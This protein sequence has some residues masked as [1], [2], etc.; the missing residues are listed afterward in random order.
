[1]ILRDFA[2]RDV[3]RLPE[4]LRP[5]RSMGFSCR[6]LQPLVLLLGGN[7]GVGKTTLAR[8]LSKHHLR[9]LNFDFLWGDLYYAA[10][11]KQFP[12]L[13][14]LS[15]HF[16]PQSIGSSLESMVKAGMADYLVNLS[17]PYFIS[18]ERL[19]IAEGYQFGIAEISQLTAQE[20]SKKGFRVHNFTL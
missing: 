19:T 14:K 20:L 4:G 17:L 9:V 10:K 13:E 15:Q 6:K 18:S 5:G 11:N 3:G 1:M 7:S 12:Y 8:E 2:V 16:N